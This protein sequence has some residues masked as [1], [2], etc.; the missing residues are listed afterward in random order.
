MQTEIA[1]AKV[2]LALHVRSRR[3]DGF[4]E[5]E[6]LFV[7]AQDGDVLG[8]V[9]LA[10]GELRLTI[11]GPFADGLD[12]GPAN[13]VMQAARALQ[14]AGG[15][16]WGAALHLTKNLP[17]A[18]GIGG[19]S[20]D[21]AATLRLLARL[22]DL[23]L[24]DLCA[25]GDP[26][27]SDVPACVISRTLVGTGRGEALDL[28]HLPALA[29]VPMLLVNPGKPLSTGPVF[30]G[31]DGIDR[32]AMDAGTLNAIVAHGR[33]DLQ[34]PALRLVPEIGDVLHVLEDQTGVVF[35]RMSGSG[36]TCFALFTDAAARDAAHRRIVQTQPDW[37]VMAT[38][39]RDL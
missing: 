29:G 32:G 19:G 9:P 13:L 16:K 7:F 17:V 3:P 1:Y 24:L 22:W 36:A 5:L 23:P 10:T 27:G 2:N 25:I 4:H 37:W 20:A 35:A 8:A 34:P 14:A 15:T 38:R 31:W 28:R 6:S 21:A 30:G 26:L 12:P 33:N 18:S 11:D 39:M